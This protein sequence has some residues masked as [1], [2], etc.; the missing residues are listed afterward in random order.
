VRNN[1]LTTTKKNQL[2]P[3]ILERPSNP[4]SVRA[5]TTKLVTEGILSLLRCCN[6]LLKT[7]VLPP[8]RF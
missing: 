1:L 4:Q 6:I 7:R 3:R 5:S 8:A 2:K